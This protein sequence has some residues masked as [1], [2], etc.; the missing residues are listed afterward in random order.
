MS[1][2]GKAATDRNPPNLL[3]ADDAEIADKGR[4]ALGYPRH[5]RNPR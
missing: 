2:A 1:Q 3:T 5:L 4:N